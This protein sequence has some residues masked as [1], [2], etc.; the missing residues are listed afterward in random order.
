MNRRELSEAQQRM[1]RKKRKAPWMKKIL[2]KYNKAE[3]IIFRMLKEKQR[4][5]KSK[6][7]IHRK[8]AKKRKRKVEKT[9]DNILIGGCFLVFLTAAFME[10]KESN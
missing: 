8:A 1:K 6:E 4:T 10:V 3:K 5:F 2:K 9:V 7:K